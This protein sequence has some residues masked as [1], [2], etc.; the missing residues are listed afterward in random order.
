MFY[1]QCHV[2]DGFEVS[3]DESCWNQKYSGI[4]V[5]RGY[6]ISPS[7]TAPSDD[8]KCT[9]NGEKLNLLSFEISTERI[10]FRHKQNF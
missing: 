7:A 2:A 8:K 6:F 5:G 4:D 10:N 9:F 3:I 1:Y